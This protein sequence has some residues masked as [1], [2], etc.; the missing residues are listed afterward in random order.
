VER[1]RA[2]GGCDRDVRRLYE[3]GE[4]CCRAFRPG[5]M[6]ERIDPSRPR[7]DLPAERALPDDLL[8]SAARSYGR[9]CIYAMR[10]HREMN[11]LF[12]MRRNVGVRSP[13]CPWSS[14]KQE[15]PWR[16]RLL[17]L[18]TS[19]AVLVFRGV[20][21]SSGHKVVSLRVTRL[22]CASAPPVVTPWVHSSFAG[23][24]EV[25]TAAMLWLREMCRRAIP[26]VAGQ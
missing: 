20:T 26:S 2:G 7:R 14:A 9:K 25:H 19:L 24:C 6:P 17:D 8:V 15:S 5:V 3:G 11:S 4:T 16:A 18:S 13:C 10:L 23:V 22:I 21:V 1:D 12:L